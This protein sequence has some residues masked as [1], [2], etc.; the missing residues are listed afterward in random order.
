MVICFMAR[1]IWTHGFGGMESHSRLL[2][3]ELGRQGH[4]VHV[5]TTSAPPGHAP[6]APCGARIHYL[7]GTPSGDYS[8]QWWRASRAWADAHLE[9]LG[10]QAVVSVSLG[11]A[12]LA[13]MTSRPPLFMICHG[14]GWS[15]L[16]GYWHDHV[17]M[18]KLGHLPRDVLAVAADLRR[19]K[20][21]LRA[22]PAVFA[23]SHDLCERLRPYAA[24]YLPNMVDVGRF[25]PDATA[26]EAM[27]RSL[28][29]GPAEIVA[30]MV[31]TV[32]RQKGVHSGLGACA[33]VG[34]SVPGLR[35]LVVGDGPAL[36]GLRRWASR[37]GSGL[38]VDFIGARRHDELPPYY[39]AA[40]LCLFPS[41]RH[42][43]LP[44]TV[45]EAMATALP[46]VAMRGGGISDALVD[47][48]TGIL[49]D[50]GDHAAFTAAVGALVTDAARRHALG[51]ASRDLVTRRFDA[52]AVTARF[53]DVLRDG[54]C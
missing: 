50:P 35:V 43:V 49:V 2:V 34:G 15:L 41:R 26:R 51:R 21:L 30:L 33:K 28:G 11:A 47:G 38:R 10:V 40:D 53:V 44:L 14:H 19:A 17:G 32:N 5:V 6:D 27:R 20:P 45:L 24:C 46:V 8:A 1:R 18:A 7:P 12:A 22:A 42:E 3:T 13:S 4:T 31:G 54:R 16:K 25:R 9:R 48:E 29:I 37:E 52:R 23:G 36:P 39:A